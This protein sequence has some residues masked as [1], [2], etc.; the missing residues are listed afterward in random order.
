MIG[1]GDLPGGGYESAAIRTS[2]DGSKVV[3]YA[4]SATGLEAFVWDSTNGI[5]G[6]GGLPGGSGESSG[7]Y[8]SADGTIVVGAASGPDGNEI[9]RWDASNGMV[10]LGIPAGCL[11]ASATD[12][13]A[14]GSIIIGFCNLEPLGDETTAIIWDETNGYR[15]LHSVLTDGGVDLVGWTIDAAWGISD[16]GTRIVG[17]ATEPGLSGQSVAFVADLAAPAPVPALGPLGTLVFTAVLVVSGTLASRSRPERLA[18][19]D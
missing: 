12:L 6:L 3:G 16:D 11:G 5:V 19:T 4:N 17:V 1:L 14:D 8:I 9:F 13:S 7:G 2:A 10:G 18:A 15:S